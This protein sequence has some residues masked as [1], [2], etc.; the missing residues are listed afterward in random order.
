MGLFEE[1]P[2]ALLGAGVND[3]ELALG[4]DDLMG[5]YLSGVSS[6]ICFCILWLRMF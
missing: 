3:A 5:S 6:H 4:T 1:Y 2:A